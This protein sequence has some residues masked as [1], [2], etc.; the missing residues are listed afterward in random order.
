MKRFICL[1][2]VFIILITGVPFVVASETAELASAVID[3][4]STESFYEKCRIYLYDGKCYM[5][6]D[7]IA[8]YTRSS[9][10]DSGDL[11]QITHG[12]RSIQI[13]ISTGLLKE[14][15]IEYEVGIMRNS[16]RVLLHAYPILT[17]LGAECSIK[18]ANTF[19]IN[20]PKVT[21]W[22]GLIRDS[23]ESYFSLDVFGDKWSIGL[24]LGLDA[25]LAFMDNGLGSAL[26]DNTMKDAMIM[27]LQVNPFEYDSVWNEKTKSDAH[28][29]SMIE[30]MIAT[31]D[32]TSDFSSLFT[33]EMNIFGDLVGNYLNNAFE[34]D[35]EFCAKLKLAKGYF[36]SMASFS[37]FLSNYAD[38]YKC[39]RDSLEIMDAF[40]QYIPEDSSYKWFAMSA[41]DTVRNELSATISAG[42]DV[43][44]KDILDAV[45]SGIED[46]FDGRAGFLNVSQ[47]ASS[48]LDISVLLYKTWHKVTNS[49]ED[50]FA[51][52]KAE[53]AAIN[54]LMLKEEIKTAISNAADNILEHNYANAEEI[55][56]YRLL[57]IFYYRVMI[58]AN[59]QMRAFV[60]AQGRED[61]KD[62]QEVFAQLDKNDENFARNLYYL[63]MSKGAAFPN[64]E[65]II[66]KNVWDSYE[67]YSIEVTSKQDDL[68]MF[69]LAMDE[70]KAFYN[71]DE[72]STIHREVP[73]GEMGPYGDL[74]KIDGE[75]GE[76]TLIRKD[77]N[78][79]QINMKNN[80][81]FYT[82]QGSPYT[83]G[84]YMVNTDGSDY[85]QI[86]DM[87]VGGIAV[88]NHYIY[89]VTDGL[90]YEE[91]PILYRVDYL[92]GKYVLEKICTLGSANEMG[93]SKIYTMGNQLLLTYSGYNR[94]TR[95]YTY[96]VFTF[97]ISTGKKTSIYNS[98]EEI[99]KHEKIWPY[100]NYVYFL[101]WENYDSG[102]RDSTL[103]PDDAYDGYL[104]DSRARKLYRYNTVSKQLEFCDLDLAD[105]SVDN[106]DP[107]YTF[108]HYEIVQDLIAPLANEMSE[109]FVGSKTFVFKPVKASDSD[110][111]GD[112]DNQEDDSYEVSG[113]ITVSYEANTATKIA[114]MDSY[115]AAFQKAYPNVTVVRDY[116]YSTA[117]AAARIKQGSIGDV[118]YFGAGDAYSFAVDQ[119]ALLPLDKY[120][121]IYDVNVNDVYKGVLDGAV[122]NGHHCYVAKDFTSMCMVYNRDA[123]KMKGVDYL[124]HNGWTFDDFLE[125]CKKVSNS[126]YY[127]AALN[128]A[129]GPVFI[130]ILEAYIGH[131]Q[132]INTENKK[133]DLTS[134]DTLKA[135]RELID[136]Y[137]NGYINLQLGTEYKSAFSGKDPVFRSAVWQAV[138]S[139][140]IEF[141][142]MDVDWDL[143]HM[144]F[145]ENPMVA[146]GSSGFGVY[147]GTDNPNAAAAFA[148]F[149]YSQEGQKAF[150][151]VG[152]GVS[153]L[154]SL[155]DSQNLPHYEDDWKYKNWE[156]LV[157]EADRYAHVG[158]FACLLPTEVANILNDG[159]YETLIKAVENP[160]ELVSAFKELEDKANQCWA[161][162]E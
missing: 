128:L 5:D 52:A 14:D 53:T 6:I 85:R 138:E 56:A 100:G 154:K 97:D 51:Y 37:S 125:I 86:T 127:G 148:L 57:N 41:R 55:E 24:R 103:S 31:N 47:I 131:N 36:K 63:T 21:V 26:F 71:G 119:K 133:V 72:Y 130:P 9:Y 109:N 114:Y 134:G 158:Q 90:F 4:F 11:L 160:D 99:R 137:R 161:N 89:F 2:L 145:T 82:I 80:H 117:H 108:Y 45:V 19:V 126:Y 60:I 93:T 43:A 94:Q 115:I 102:L 18:D 8:K 30:A 152:D 74:Y 75:T 124:V 104:E 149:A 50:I 49:G 98:V 77:T 96:D 29:D 67:N 64:I 79:C 116:T 32:F 66:H 3:V 155:G 162:I 107:Y 48:S 150:L 147:S 40:L 140:G 141:D 146:F 136:A 22:E 122:V 139:Y 42:L 46:T 101:K 10:N 92:S 87:A 95:K 1:F 65:D 38:N 73:A 106:S 151:E 129:Y 143:I 132:W 13:A 59:E 105:Y 70:Y 35:V 58:A 144:P 23:Y 12:T 81:I 91:Q 111:I 34:E 20:M 33:D 27:S 153:T 83:V 15:G 17:Y 69:Y 112:T 28:L 76:K 118:F 39:T 16:G 62:M 25:I 156:T 113:T 159:L 157:Y 110:D 7:D 54:L 135:V 44:K 120:I 61:E 68:S 78:A 88:D 142:T 123:L 84:V 121:E